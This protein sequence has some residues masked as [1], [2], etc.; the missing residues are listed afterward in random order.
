MN[1][2]LAQKWQHTR[3]WGNEV[4]RASAPPAF[5][6]H[7]NWEHPHNIVRGLPPMSSIIGVN[8][9]PVHNN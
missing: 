4:S 5:N 1:R 7:Y 8:S 2:T 6:E 9:L 3:T